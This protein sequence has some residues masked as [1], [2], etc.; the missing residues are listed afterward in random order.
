MSPCV[1]CGAEGLDADR[2]GA[3]CEDCGRAVLC[4]PACVASGIWPTC[5]DCFDVAH[6]DRL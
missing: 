6:D 2:H 3:E 5:T 4:C 1:G